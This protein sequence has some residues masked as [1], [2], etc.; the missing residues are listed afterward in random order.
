MGWIA[1]IV[2]F[3]NAIISLVLVCVYLDNLTERMVNVR[4]ELDM[5]NISIRSETLRRLDAIETIPDNEPP[6]RQL[7]T[8]EQSCIESTAQEIVN[9]PPCTE[10]KE[11]TE[12]DVKSPRT[13]S[14]PCT[15]STLQK[16]DTKPPCTESIEE[17]ISDIRLSTK[18]TIQETN[19]KSPCQELT[20]SNAE[21]CTVFIPCESGSNTTCM[22]FKTEEKIDLEC[23]TEEK[24]T[25]HRL[26]SSNYE[27]IQFPCV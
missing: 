8:Y 3:L 20:S 19:T 13:E 26:E 11:Q 17:Q 21:P 1:T 14:T 16:S 7:P 6:S 23:T 22:Q 18:S 27:E 9:N 12:D 10:L 2:A 5:D 24:K 15:D 4:E 25:L